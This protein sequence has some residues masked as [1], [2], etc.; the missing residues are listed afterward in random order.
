M[1]MKLGLLTCIA[2][3]KEQFIRKTKPKTYDFF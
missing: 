2:L 1:K 3:E